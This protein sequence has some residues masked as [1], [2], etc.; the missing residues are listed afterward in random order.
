[1]V[2]TSKTPK[3]KK[4]LEKIAKRI[5]E[6]KLQLVEVLLKMPVVQVAVKKVGIARSTYYR[7][8]EEDAEF[9]RVAT[10]AVREGSMVINELAQSKLIEEMSKGNMTAAI[11]W[12]KSRDPKFS[13]RRTVINEFKV[14]AKHPE[15]T[16]EVKEQIDNV[17]D[18]FTRAANAV[19][20]RYD[21]THPDYVDDEDRYSDK[22]V[23][24]Y[25]ESGG[26]E[27]EEDAI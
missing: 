7:W 21:T 16:E 4:E 8:C 3:N 18:L 12:L 14:Q 13:D 11:F 5:A 2:K 20:H 23:K 19:V 25:L 6:Q 22:P 27:T 15:V 17:F 24:G 10:E 26:L 9:D 1:M